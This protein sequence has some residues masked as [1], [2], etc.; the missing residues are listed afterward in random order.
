MQ[1]LDDIALLREF[2][3][4]NSEDAF[5]ILV[6]RN[7][8]KVYSIALRQT[9]NPDQAEEIT[10]AVFVI[11][12][13]KSSVLCQR[14]VLS[15]WLHETTR[16]TAITFIRREFRRTRRER[17]ACMQNLLN[18][19]APDVW[20]QIAPLLDSAISRLSEK[21]RHVILLRYFDAKSM[22]EV[23]AALGANEDAAKKRVNRAVEKLRAFFAK[24][25]IATSGSV[26]VSAISANSIQIAPVTLAQSVT[27]VAFTKGSIAAAST[28]TLVKG[29]LNL[30]A[31]I[32]TKT[33]IFFCA[34]A[35]TA[36][37][38]VE[39]A[40]KTMDKFMD[41]FAKTAIGEQTMEATD[42]LGSLQEEGRLP[43]YTLGTNVASSFVIPGIRYMNEKTGWEITATNIEPFPISRTFDLMTNAGK[44]LKWHYTVVKAKKKGDWKITKAWQT[45]QSGKTNAMFPISVDKTTTP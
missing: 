9:R 44:G 14:T 41:K 43:G 39:L 23:A 21:D 3:E 6:S 42:F 8:N 19:P 33:T 29:T 35:L 15:G 30:M 20:P 24:R 31:W 5:A 17:E 38:G 12:A 32:K 13:Q 10:Q 25:G 4:R 27:A 22:K 37:G 16:L 40:S 2:V 45:D 18:E 34:V 28:A 11:L 7:I 1:E 26:L 36:A